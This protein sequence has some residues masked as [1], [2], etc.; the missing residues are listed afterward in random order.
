MK[1]IHASMLLAADFG[2]PIVGPMILAWSVFLNAMQH[3]VAKDQQSGGFQDDYPTQF[4]DLMNELQGAMDDDVIDF[5]A[6]QAVN[7]CRVFETL[8]SISTG[9]GHTPN[10]FLSSRS[11]SMMRICV[12]ELIKDVVGIGYIPE[13]VEA[14]LSALTAGQTYWDVVDS[15]TLLRSED[16]AFTFLGAENLVRDL[17]EK[18]QARYP[19]ESLPFL[20]MVRAIAAS[21]LLYGAYGGSELPRGDV[22]LLNFLRETPVFTYTLPV[23]FVDY[24][25]FYEEENN[26]NIRLTRAVQ[27]FEPRSKLGR[28]AQNVSLALVRVDQTFVIPA[29]TSGRIISDSGPR[30]GLW[31]HK[32]SALQYFGK[33]LETFL[34]A[35]DQIDATTGMPADRDSVSEIIGLFAAMLN[36][37]ARASTRTGEWHQEALEVLNQ[38]RAGLSRNRDIVTVIFEIFEEEL[39]HQPTSGS[40]AS[41][42]ILVACIQF[43]HAVLPVAPGRVWPLIAR[44]G[45]LGVNTGTGRLSGIVEGVELLVG[46]F[47]FLTS[48]CRLFDALIDDLSTNA[49]RR[50]VGSKSTARFDGISQIGVCVPDQSLSKVILC[51]TRYLID[52]LE[53]SSTWKFVSPDE[54]RCLTKTIGTALD[55]ILRYYYGTDSSIDVVAGDDTVPDRKLV[56][57]LEPKKEES[58]E[59]RPLMGVLLPAATHIVESFLATASGT[60]RFQSLLRSYFDG[61][62]TPGCTVYL[63]QSSMWE[64]TVNSIL[65]FSNTL[66][67][68][69]I[70]L[71]RPSSQLEKQIFKASPIVAR[72]YA[73]NDSYRP[74]VLS[75]LGS[76]IEA[77]ANETSEPPSL[78]GHLGPQ[79]TQRFLRLLSEVDK[80]FS[81][82]SNITKI[83]H[84][85]AM[86]VSCRQQWFAN[87]LLT[88]K[89]PRTLL[90]KKGTGGD[91]AKPST[92][93]LAIALKTL[94]NIEHLS[95]LEAL[96][97]L[98]FV[99]LAQNFWPWTVC[100]SSEYPGFV[101][102]I[103]EFVGTFAPPQLRNGSPDDHIETCFQLRTA[104]YVA[105]IL[106]MH[107][108]HSRQTGKPV[109]LDKFLPNL[110]FFER[111]AASVPYYNGN[112]H[113]LLKRNFETRYSDC[114]VRDLKHTTLEVHQF[115]KDYYYDLSLASKMLS[116]DQAWYGKNNDGMKAE[117]E[118]ANVNL[119]IVDAHNVSS[120][121][122]VVDLS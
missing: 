32:Y 57:T 62:E 10:S 73:A 102:A 55:N 122:M 118:R 8:S 14:T 21:P 113:T 119:S 96:A 15:G 29:G 68:V 30:I 31:F 84:F 7:Q 34:T 43:I 80:P 56:L 60:L 54:R 6:R 94:S 58:K 87:Y 88:G 9:L 37:F 12:L 121:A 1:E 105:E 109:A 117:F 76:L 26:N 72:L 33:L 46:Q 74:T 45:L 79:T 23:D 93:F 120:P 44:S 69:N 116:L 108:F 91:S 24:E 83:W 86:I 52:V 35:S 95:Q 65:R 78:L 3:R 38:A 4:E 85:L 16:P 61:L 115:G 99:A 13:I 53:T 112:L 22:F 20:Q 41:L 67:R 19:F 107:L 51:F 114:T 36:G 27:L 39:Y 101:N 70:L 40:D 77:A 63:K 71:E 64:E 103:L 110:T 25:T 82:D 111:F 100:D 90:E 106:A 42:D 18:A 11:G 98:E 17:L 92:S 97:T 2:I 89:T 104:A 5:L 66:L 50:K 81:R 49:L 48:C 59:P 47:P 75:L 28:G